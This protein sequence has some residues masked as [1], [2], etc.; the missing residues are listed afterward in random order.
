MPPR[1]K[2]P[3]WRFSPA[4][5]KLRLVAFAKRRLPVRWLD[6]INHF[7]IQTRLLFSRFVILLLVA[8]FVFFTWATVQNAR[9]GEQMSQHNSGFNKTE[10]QEGSIYGFLLGQSIM[11]ALILH[12]GLW[13]SERE[14]RTLEF[15]VMRIPNVHA[16]IWF[17]LR[18]SLFWTFALL[19]PF[20]LGFVWFYSISFGHA[21][22]S[23]V[24]S[25]VE[26]IFFAMFTCVVASFVHHPLPTG[27]IVV[28]LGWIFLGFT[29]GTPLF[30]KDYYK[31]IM[32]P[33][34]DMYSTWETFDLV[35]MV[36]INRL[37]QILE[38]LGFYAWFAHRLTTRMEK[39]IG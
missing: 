39:W 12:M 17:K 30:Y 28:I 3:P 32:Y 15:L 9:S 19:F 6:E 11:L 4:E 1:E 38:A 21:C 37:V 29:E 23:L 34:D 14:E 35:R 18:V 16:L 27:I 13:E 22:Y 5:L 31:P 25:C 36:V 2:R 10:F 20:F 26:A 33:F 8:M 24:S 7:A